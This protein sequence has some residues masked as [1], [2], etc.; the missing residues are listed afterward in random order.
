MMNLFRLLLTKY[1]SGKSER[2]DG[3]NLF[4]G[5]YATAEQYEIINKL[6]PS[7]FLNSAI[8]R[9][10]YGNDT[11]VFW[12]S[13]R[14]AATRGVRSIALLDQ[15]FSNESMMLRLELLKRNRPPSLEHIELFNELPHM[16]YPGQQINSLEDLIVKTNRYSDW[17]HAN[18]PGVKVITM[19]P[20][21]S[22]DERSFP[23]WGGV[24]NTR[25]LKDLVLYTTADIAAI[26][27]Y[28]DSLGKQMAMFD[29]ADNL[30]AWNKEAKFKKKVWI[31]EIGDDKW[32]N[33]VKFYRDTVRL[34]V[35]VL[36]PEKVIWYRHSIDQLLSLDSGFALEV[37]SN[38]VHS[39][40]WDELMKERS[41]KLDI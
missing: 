1:F 30:D 25:I 12:Q 41:W 22:I 27:I 20:Y 39:P 37:R 7:S 35:N 31:T 9:T 23:D 21:N 29:L 3:A 33:H 11:E 32:D 17:I 15:F 34:A 4:A 5:E 13:V 40:L 19:A 28:G 18:M 14:N 8:I 10:P 6:Y 24:T 2:L 38:G 36:K 26:H 16:T